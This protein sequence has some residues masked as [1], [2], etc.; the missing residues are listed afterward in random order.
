MAM[1]I[2]SKFSSSLSGFLVLQNIVYRNLPERDRQQFTF[3]EIIFIF[4]ERVENFHGQKRIV[5]KISSRLYLKVSLRNNL[6]SLEWFPHKKNSEKHNFS[7]KFA[8]VCFW[9]YE[10]KIEKLENTK[11]IRNRDKKLKSQTFF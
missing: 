4:F 10:M 1:K 7:I 6:I 8:A 9:E 2:V 5:N 11:K 3:L